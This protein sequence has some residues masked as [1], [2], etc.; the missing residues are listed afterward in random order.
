MSMFHGNPHYYHN[1]LYSQV[2]AANAR[3]EEPLRHLPSELLIPI[4]GMAATGSC[5]TGVALALA[6]PWIADVT[7]PAR[8]A[9]VTLRTEKQV[10]SFKTLV[11]SS[12][13]AAD[14]VRTLWLA[15]GIG[16]TAESV[17][18]S[19]LT[20]CSHIRALACPLAPLEAL[21]TSE[22]PF[23]PWFLSVHLNLLRHSDER[24]WMHLAN[25]LN[26]STF[27]HHLTHL[28]ISCPVSQLRESFP[29]QDFPR[30]T[31]L[32]VGSESYWSRSPDEYAS[33]I[34]HFA[35]ALGRVWESTSLQLA[36]LVF[37]AYSHHP[38]QGVYSR[39]LR[40]GW[41]ARELVRTAREIC[42][43]IILA[44]CAPLRPDNSFHESD[45]WAECAANGE[46]IWTLAQKQ[47]ALFAD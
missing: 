7:L 30:L 2:L 26:G 45:F 3:G 38:Y 43:S 18:A 35:H 13:R 11:Y 16:R 42:G 25:T 37:R 31:H 15:H 34:Q 5:T 44:Y 27:L 10:L 22:Q 47:A 24:T 14:A 21:C 36:V 28:R 46:D 4:L 20:A 12:D 40:P 29:A 33:Y 8:L 17:M 6:S 32:A 1:H 23:P 39:H 19:I 41:Q 9:H